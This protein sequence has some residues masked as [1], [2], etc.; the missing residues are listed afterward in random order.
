[1]IEKNKKEKEQL[2]TKNRQLEEN[3]A[4]MNRFYSEEMQNLKGKFESSIIQRVVIKI[5]IYNKYL[6]FL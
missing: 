3:L 1:M 2:K 5:L 6:M 4:D